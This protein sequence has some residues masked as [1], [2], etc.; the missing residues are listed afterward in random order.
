M[1][2]EACNAMQLLAVHILLHVFLWSSCSLMV[3]A[4]RVHMLTIFFISKYNYTFLVFFFRKNTYPCLHTLLLVRALR[5]LFFALPN[6]V[7]RRIRH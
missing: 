6:L 1:H 5:S 7:K 4:K 2:V 3:D